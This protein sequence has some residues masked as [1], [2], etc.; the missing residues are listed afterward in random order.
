MILYG[1][2]MSPFARRVAIWCDLQ[3]REVERRQLLVAGPQ[4]EE[5]KAVNPLGRVPALVLDD[6]EVLVETAA[7]IDHLEE[8]APEEARLLPAGGAERRRTLQDIAYATSTAEKIVALV[9]DK[10]RRPEEFHYP[11]W[12]E[13]LEGQIRAGIQVLEGRVPEAGW[14]SRT[15]QPMGGD[16]AVAIA[17]EMVEVVFPDLDVGDTPMLDRL[18]ADMRGLPAFAETRPKP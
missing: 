6:G 7:I 5:I 11:A 12:I 14:L 1:R 9:Y 2:D 15:D 16:I 4:W 17:G 10:V 13:R 3:G 18:V 8:T